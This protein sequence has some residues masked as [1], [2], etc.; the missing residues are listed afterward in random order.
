M[1][2]E[3]L[4]QSEIEDA[5]LDNVNERLE[6]VTIHGIAWSVQVERND[7]FGLEKGHMGC[8]YQ[9]QDQGDL[10]ANAYGLTISDAVWNAL[11]RLE[12]IVGD[13]TPQEIIAVEE[14]M[15]GFL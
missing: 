11:A 1:I 6:A 14:A 10:W 15:E 7:L 3:K 9:G 2:Y 8:V 5:V 4:T 12:E 13:M